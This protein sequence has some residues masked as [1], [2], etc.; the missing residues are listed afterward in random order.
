MWNWEFGM[1]AYNIHYKV[2]IQ[3][4]DEADFLEILHYFE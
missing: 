4:D 2:T 1:S 3:F